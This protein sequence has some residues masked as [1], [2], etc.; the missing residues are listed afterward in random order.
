MR[1]QGAHEGDFAGVPIGTTQRPAFSIG[2]VFMPLSIG[3]GI[4]Y[5][6]IMLTI[7]TLCFN[8]TIRDNIIL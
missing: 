8:Y 3:V 5:W 1:R 6:D 4:G 7:C 2:I